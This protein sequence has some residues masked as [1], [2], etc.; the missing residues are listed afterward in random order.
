[1]GGHIRFVIEKMKVLLVFAL[2]AVAFSM[3]ARPQMELQEG[4]EFKGLCNLCVDGIDIVQT[5][6]KGFDAEEKK[7]VHSL[8]D[9]I[10]LF[11]DMSKM[12]ADKAIDYIE[13]VKPNNLC[14]KFGAC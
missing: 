2:V 11:G 3:A 12:Y 5:F 8:C 4:I 9:K 7:Q 6:I 1:M 13:K 10:P 14:T